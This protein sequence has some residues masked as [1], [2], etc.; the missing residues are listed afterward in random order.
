M[1]KLVKYVF[2]KNIPLVS[3][4]STDAKEKILKAK[5]HG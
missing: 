3:T 4:V 1:L 5:E 2:I